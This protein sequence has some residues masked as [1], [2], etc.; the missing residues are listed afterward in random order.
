[1]NRPYFW[2]SLSWYTSPIGSVCICAC[3]FLVFLIGMV[4]WGSGGRLVE[5][6]KDG[7]DLQR[8]KGLNEY[9]DEVW[10]V[11]TAKASYQ[12]GPINGA[13]ITG[14]ATSTNAA[15]AVSTSV[16]TNTGSW[17]GTL[18][19][20]NVHWMV[21][22]TTSGIDVQLDVGRVQ[23]NGANTIIIQTEIEEDATA[24]SLLFQIC[25]W[26]NTDSV[27][28]VADSQC[29]GGGWRTLNLAKTA[30]AP[31]TYTAYHY[32][33]YDGYWPKSSNATSS[34]STPLTNFINGDR[35]KIR[36]FSTTNT[37]TALGID[38]LRVYAVINPIYTAA[39]AMGLSTS[40]LTVAGSFASTTIGVGQTGSDNAYMTV[41]GT[42]TNPADYY[43]SFK[44]VKTYTGMNTIVVR[45]EHSC[46][47]ANTVSYQLYIRNFAS[48]TWEQ[49]NSGS[50]LCSTSDTTGQY[51]K[52]GITM[53]DYISDGE[54]R[55]R[56]LATVAS[57]TIGLRQDIVYLMLGSTNTDTNGKEISLGVASTTG[58][59]TGTRDMWDG[60]VNSWNITTEDESANFS[61]DYYPYNTDMDINVEEAAAA[62]L[63]FPV[64]VPTNAAVTGVFF[65][66]RFMA[67]TGGTVQMALRDYGGRT[68]TQGGWVSVGGT[69]TTAQTYTDNYTVASVATGGLAGYTTNPADFVNTVSSTM[70][71]ALRTTTDGS[72]ASNAV[73]Q[74]DF[75]MVSIQWVE[76]AAHPT[77]RFRFTPSGGGIVTGTATST[78]AA[79]AVSTS[80][81]LNVGSWRGTLADDNA[82]WMVLSTTS[83][84]N[85]Y[86]DVDDVDLNNSNMLM[87]QTE[88]DEDAT[89]PALILQICDW[90]SATSVDAPADS[91]C[92]G[93]GWRTLNANKAT[94]AP[95]AYTVYYYQVYDGYWSGTSATSTP[96]STPLTNFVNT[97]SGNKIRVRY[98]STTNTTTPLGIDYLFVQAVTNPVYGPA[99]LTVSTLNATTTGR[100]ASTTI[101]AGGQT[102][103][104]NAYLTVTGTATAAA[105]YALDFYNVRT[106]PGAN[107]IL[108]RSEFS[109]S[110][111]GISSRPKIY[112]FSSSSWEYLSGAAVACSAT[113]QIGIWA[114]SNVS[115]GDYLS[116]TST[117]RIGWEGSAA[118]ATVALRLD[119]IYA[120]IGTTNSSTSTSA[121]EV[122]FGTA[123][124][125]SVAFTRDIDTS[126]TTLSWNINTE[127]ESKTF[128][129]DYYPYN[130]DMDVNIEEAA[131]AH[132]NFPVTVPASSSVTG[133]FYASRHT[134]GTAG[135]A[136]LG[137]RDFGGFTGLS[138]GWS[139]LTSSTATTAFTYIDN[140]VMGT[141]AGGIFGF[142][143]NPEDYVDTV[144]STTALAL[145]TSVDGATT[146]NSVRQWDFAMTS[147]QWVEYPSSTPEASQEISLSISDNL[148]GFGSLLTT[149]S[150]YATGDEN[151]TTTPTSAHT[152]AVATNADNGFSLAIN[153]STLTST[154]NSSWTI[155]AIGGTATSPASGTEQFGVR[156]TVSGGS[157]SV[158]S[159]YD[160]SGYAFDA[161]NFPDI[162]G[163]AASQS[164]TSTYSA[165]YIASIDSLT[166]PGAY[167]TNI[168]YILTGNF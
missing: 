55:V 17:R 49:L 47:T 145:R 157:G 1:M 67:G 95:T 111:T 125:S 42:A 51:A 45:S 18:A 9:V 132:I 2:R 34:V 76:D 137:L 93:G 28:R 147:F 46:S 64:T 153:G 88:V 10:G 90:T 133:I 38:Y 156:Y 7:I 27:D 79:A 62:N 61:H 53:S 135:T 148:I 99:A 112:N 127:D 83:G 105:D 104:D 75:A 21:L 123:S 121:Y 26:V 84:I 70:N 164:A 118:S 36:Y 78:N 102:G 87:F 35:I 152:I 59:V 20:D 161:N 37:T 144:S 6:Q 114:K 117:L 108:V 130:T 33:I 109:C 71:L 119:F 167:S 15:S 97:S 139:H 11:P 107:T 143:P 122:S 63:N 134:A 85:L 5:G 19:D 96:A 29:T 160:T 136:I 138:G 120:M 91:Q 65:A 82:H 98:F 57:A 23:L 8:L 60:T 92:T 151:G 124:T 154:Q 126:S 4:F 113:D 159:P 150:T 74:W 12:F 14:T 86:L 30:V 43:Y 52:S 103:S 58:S 50:I 54:I 41:T 166:E 73:R 94:V 128:G 66:G 24:P 69:A 16:D 13:I 89:S 116:S 162:I 68:S 131:A 106:Y 40:T 80:V 149:T 146:N 101:A 25:D 142:I 72:T 100:V 163:T 22:S 129:H 141:A 115:I 56:Y 77:Q 44:N 110:T 165:Y 81:D 31:T 168:T 155:D 48:S 140:V 3:I 32:Q 158:S 39:G